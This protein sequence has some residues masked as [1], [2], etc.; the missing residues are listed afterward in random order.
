MKNLITDNSTQKRNGQHEGGRKSTRA[1][2]LAPDQLI[3]LGS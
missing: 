3:Y 2:Q 1:S